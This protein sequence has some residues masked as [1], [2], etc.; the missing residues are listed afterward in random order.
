MRTAQPRYTGA[1]ALAAA[2]LV[3]LICAPFI[4]PKSA[5]AQTPYDVY[6]AVVTS[7]SGSN[8]GYARGSYGS[9]SPEGF[10]IGGVRS[11]LRYLTW[12][13]RDERFNLAFASQPP[14]PLT[15][16]Q[17]EGGTEFSCSASS[18]LSY[19]C[20]T[21]GEDA[22]WSRNQSHNVKLTFT[23]PTPSPGTS[24]VP[25]ADVFPPAPED[26][27][28][29]AYGSR[30][31]GRDINLA[32]ANDNPH[33]I[34]S[35]GTTMWVVDYTDDKAYAYTLS[36][37]NR[38]VGKE[39]DIPVVGARHPTGITGSS[40]DGW[41]YIAS[42]G[43]GTTGHINKYNYT[44]S[45]SGSITVTADGTALVLSSL[46]RLLSTLTS[47]LGSPITLYAAHEQYGTN[48]VISINPPSGSP[49][50]LRVSRPGYRGVFHNGARLLVYSFGSSKDVIRVLPTPTESLFRPG[51]TTNARGMWGNRNTLWITDS[52]TNVNVV[53]AHYFR[54]LTKEELER[55]FST[56]AF[57]QNPP[58][59]KDVSLGNSYSVGKATV[60]NVE[61]SWVHTSRLQEASGDAKTVA[62]VEYE[63]DSRTTGKVGPILVSPYPA[64]VTIQAL[65]KSDY[66]LNIRVRY[67]WLNNS[68][69]EISINN[70]PGSGTC[71]DK[72]EE[73]YNTPGCAFKLPAGEKRTS[74]WSD[75]HAV[76]ISGF[77]IPVPDIGGVEDAQYHGITG[78][79]AEG[80]MIIGVAP[81]NSMELGG[82]LT[83][84]GWLGLSLILGILAFFGSGAS[85]V[86]VY[87]GTFITLIIWSGLGPFIANIPW[88][89][90]YLPAAVLI[91][92]LGLF[93]IK[94]VG[95]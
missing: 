73:D 85:G 23:E 6:F 30:D 7:G 63:Y 65:P 81:D 77:L 39:F 50:R 9:A 31:F 14:Y 5:L 57:V 24:P 2:A 54:K 51:Y 15:S 47:D 28:Y 59:I 29:G 78:A 82:T 94:K 67:E 70:P 4:V 41:M 46:S 16:V 91:M 45:S 20:S 18:T 71:T 36:S 37:G 42:D 13:S 95:V 49:T 55:A 44:I 21:D 19:H 10:T 27:F 1:S 86:S 58:T 69:N 52:D 75:I 40:S 26:V 3:L 25:P 74:A 33:D 34:W 68:A 66:N 60:A 12:N 87:L 53:K 89:M 11:S 79:V 61:L 48:E 80:L 8:T 64:S 76:Q 38:D 84:I 92:A 32:S 88:P 43:N 62:R 35:D 17:V 22:P 56:S 90:A 93:A 83:I 72:D